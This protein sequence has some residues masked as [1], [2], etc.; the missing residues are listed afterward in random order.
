MINTRVDGS[1]LVLR[2]PSP[3]CQQVRRRLV[4]SVVRQWKIPRR[5]HIYHVD[6]SGTASVVA[7]ELQTVRWL[8]AVAPWHPARVCGC[9]GCLRC[10]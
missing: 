9:E 6:K 3:G 2:S 5:T 10:R 8:D 7:N 1:I 4:M